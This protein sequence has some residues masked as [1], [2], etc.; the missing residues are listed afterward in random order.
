MTHAALAQSPGEPA[1]A[2][3]ATEL[4]ARAHFGVATA[5][6]DVPA[7]EEAKGQAFVF[8]AGASYGLSDP[9]S[10]ELQVPLALG[11]VAQPAGSYVDA[12]A[13]G[14]PVLG[15]RYRFIERGSA[16]SVLRLFSMLE[17]GAPLASHAPDLMPNR[18]LAI[19]DGVGGRGNPE[20]FTPGVLPI[21]ASSALAWSAAP[22]TL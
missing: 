18:L 22:W 20:W 4:E 13:A 15:A 19:A 21:T 9:L 10:L 2:S 14:N 12:A 6:F 3:G 5:P 16:R 17:I 7:L 8:A 1:L 11:S